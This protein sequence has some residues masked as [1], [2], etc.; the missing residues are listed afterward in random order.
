MAFEATFRKTDPTARSRAGRKLRPLPML[1]PRP[2]GAVIQ[3]WARD[4]RASAS[5]AH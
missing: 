1:A 4:G 5:A 3:A 2:V